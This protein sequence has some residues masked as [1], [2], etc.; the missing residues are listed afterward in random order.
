MP[1]RPP[2]SSQ[3]Q[4][5]IIQPKAFRS[6]SPVGVDEDEESSGESDDNPE[7]EEELAFKLTYNAAVEIPPKTGST[8]MKKLPEALTKRGVKQ[9]ELTPMA[10]FDWQ[11]D[12]ENK[13]PEGWSYRFDSL[14]ALV[15]HEGSA[16]K[17]GNPVA[18]GNDGEGLADVF[19]LLRGVS[20]ERTKNK[21]WVKF[22]ALFTAVQLTPTAPPP[23]QSQ[24]AGPRPSRRV[25]VEGE[26]AS[27]K[28]LLPRVR[29]LKLTILRIL[30]QLRVTTSPLSFVSR[31]A[32]MAIAGI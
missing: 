12:A 11:I 9:S 15:S 21:P 28:R 24:V 1:M 13:A 18:V 25:V 23:T 17:A 5:T 26:G 16:E 10:L 22:T 3:P 19:D 7:E 14:G 31:L 2:P 27:K 29:K 4:V 20:E 30:K 6:R 32:R 8:K